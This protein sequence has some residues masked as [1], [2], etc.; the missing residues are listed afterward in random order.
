MDV[1]YTSAYSVWK[2][3]CKT[4]LGVE[5]DDLAEGFFHDS[6]LISSYYNVTVLNGNADKI[7]LEIKQIDGVKNVKISQN[8]SEEPLIN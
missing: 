6:P 4:Y 5:N 1:E 2:E 8:E 3:Y 7:S